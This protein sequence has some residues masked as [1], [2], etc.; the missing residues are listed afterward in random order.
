MK[1]ALRVTVERHGASY[2]AT[3]RND[4]WWATGEF[5]NSL[6]AAIDSADHALGE[7]LAPHTENDIFKDLLG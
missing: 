2:L 4:C 1:W 5:C 7:V 6:Q 3:A